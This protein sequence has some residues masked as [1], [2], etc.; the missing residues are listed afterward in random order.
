MVGQPTSQAAEIL[1]DPFENRRSA[2]PPPPPPKP[3][4]RQSTSQTF[5]SSHSQS[6]V[7]PPPSPTRPVA[8][9][10]APQLAQAT[11]KRASKLTKAAPVVAAA[12]VPIA[13]P[14]AMTPSSSADTYLAP[15]PT[16]ET[17]LPLTETPFIPPPARCKSLQAT[18]SGDEAAAMLTAGGLSPACATRPLSPGAAADPY[19]LYSST[20]DQSSSLNFSIG[21]DGESGRRVLMLS[22]QSANAPAMGRSPSGLSQYYTGRVPDEGPDEKDE[23]RAVAGAPASPNGGVWNRMSSR[24]KKLSLLALLVAVIV[25][26]VAVAVPFAVR[27]GRNSHLA[28]EA[29]T[30]QAGP[31]TTQSAP[32]GVPTGGSNEI[33]RAHV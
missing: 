5:T 18:V 24:S 3:R 31:T 11:P 8:S 33:G 12:A 9:T 15:S 20:S 13:V 17:F 1:T 2:A 4:S 28:A 10:S 22:Q 30:T 19:H 29:A 23:E 25:I 14:R 16:D 26:A 27:S 7:S 32:T 6:H 21:D